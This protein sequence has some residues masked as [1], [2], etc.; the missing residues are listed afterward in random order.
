M[1]QPDASDREIVIE[2]VFDA[3]RKLVWDVWTQPKH[4]TRW[5]G[6]RGYSVRVVS[7]D[8][9]AGGKWDYR[10]VA[11][12]GQEF[13]MNGVFLEVIPMEKIVTTDDFG[14]GV[15]E[16]VKVPLPKGVVVT[17]TFADAGPKTK[18]TLRI[19]HATPEEKA[20][21]AAMGV[22][23]GWNSSFECMDEHLAKFGRSIGFA[24]KSK[25]FVN[26]PVKD[27][28]RS[29]DFFYA[30]GFTFN[31]TFTDE[32]AACLVVT[33]DIFVMLLTVPKFKEFTPKAIVD[34][35][36]QTEVITCLSCDSADRVKE[37]VAKA[38]ASGGTAYSE[39]KD[40]GFMYLHGFQ[41]PDGHNWELFFMDPAAAPG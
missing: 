25:I 38:L 35:T 26:V 24:M 15:E 36:A 4:I 28:N 27:L 20:K 13:P 30:L 39:P 7:L 23:A 5:S 22:V 9:R 29:M 31:P 3:P 1:S 10:M 21:H 40:Y 16:R 32:T 14:E 6:P 11:P 17:V 33:D 41:D 18:L 12:D 37:L 19:V 2:R 34:A 8:F